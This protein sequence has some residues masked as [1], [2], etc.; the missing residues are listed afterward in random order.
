HLLAEPVPE[1]LDALDAV[2]AG[3]FVT[4]ERLVAQ[5]ARRFDLLGDDPQ[6]RPETVLGERLAEL[7]ALGLVRVRAQA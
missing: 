2:G 5:I 1:L 3:T 7:A 4:A 6:E